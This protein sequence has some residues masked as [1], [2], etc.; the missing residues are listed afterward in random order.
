V[1]A[2]GEP[3]WTTDT[4]QLYVGDGV[5][6]GGVLVAGGGGSSTNTFVTANIE[7]ELAIGTGTYR[8]LLG[9]SP[10]PFDSQFYITGNEQVNDKLFFDRWNS[11]NFNS[12]V[13]I[14]NT[15]SISALDIGLNNGSRSFG[16]GFMPSNAN[17]MKFET[18]N[19]GASMFFALK[20]SSGVEK[21]VGISRQGHIILQNGGLFNGFPG[22]IGL[23]SL[24]GG[25]V[26]ASALY[27]DGV[28]SPY[29]GVFIN[30]Q[31]GVTLATS[32]Y[33]YETDTGVN[34]EATLDMDGN[35]TLPKDLIVPTNVYIGTGTSRVYETIDGDN[36]LNVYSPNHIEI[37]GDGGAGQGVKIYPHGNVY[38][39]G[40]ID[41]TEGSI[42]SMTGFRAG[43]YGGT[44]G[45]SFKSD[46]AQDTGMFSW[47][48]GDLRLRSNGDDVLQMASTYAQFNKKVVLN[49][50]DI[51]GGTSEDNI[52]SLPTGSGA[53]LTSS[54]EGSVSLRASTDN[55]TFKTLSFDSN[56]L[57]D[58]A[59]R[60]NASTIYASSETQDLSLTANF[61]GAGSGAGGSVNIYSAAGVA[62]AAKVEVLGDLVQI[63]S[64]DGSIEVATFDPF[65]ITST[66]NSTLTIAQASI[67]LNNGA[68]SV[69]V[70]VSNANDMKIEN[71]N[72]GGSFIF[73][74]KS[75]SGVERGVAIS[76]QGNV[77]LE[78]GQIGNAFPN[79]IN[80]QANDSGV[81][82]LN[83]QFDDGETTYQGGYL[84]ISNDAGISLLVDHYDYGTDFYESF[85]TVFGYDGVTTFPGEIVLANANE[86]GG[87]GYAGMITMTNNT[88]GA[89]NINKYV[90]LNSTGNLQIIDSAYTTNLF[91]LTD[92]GDLTIPGKLSSNVTYGT[93]YNTST[94]VPGAAN[95]AYVVPLNTQNGSNNVSYSGTGTV[96]VAKAGVYN[97]QYSIQ[98]INT[99]NSGEHDFDVWFRKNG[100]DI[101][102]SNTQFTIIK[103][104][105]KAVAAINFI[106]NLAANDTFELAYAVTNTAVHIETVAG[107]SSPYAR[108]AAPGVI[109]TVVPVGA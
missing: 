104:N 7:T 80:F 83:T 64:S 41:G 2:D 37:N 44:S 106:E 52:L 71:P 16:Y 60:I 13:E 8:M 20:N 17:N 51:V 15:A 70:L 42:A 30:T 54:L 21:N 59:S 93:F 90:R 67:G 35:F 10:I 6:P 107:Q 29:N 1:F 99:D 84:N 48:D 36:R 46:G 27:D 23:Q 40:G 96:T 78:N 73:A 19:N 43:W 18:P 26:N 65:G 5:T 9:Q 25:E 89:S 11:V 74:T 55:T 22:G 91:D 94:V 56:A 49:A 14:V 103:N 108:P 34:Y 58:G 39:D 47:G 97:I 76:R 95:T 53:S 28:T 72:N 33:I 81:V 85:E 50:V 57:L 38:I 32:N 77:I 61:N 66:V 79:G 86:H 101:P 63:K 4:T 100:V 87:T 92:T 105:G 68:R 69:G 3:V 12:D 31:T 24:D 82:N 88:D 102:N 98:L 109:L 75:P 62:G 45:Y